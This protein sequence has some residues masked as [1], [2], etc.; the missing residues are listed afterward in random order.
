MR[1]A[2]VYGALAVLAL[3]TFTTTSQA[4]MQA[5]HDTLLFTSVFRGVA[6]PAQY[7]YLDQA[8]VDYGPGAFSAAGSEQSIRFFTI[9]AGDLKFTI[10]RKT[11]MYGPGKNFVVSSGTVVR[12]SNESRTVKARVFV[13]SLVPPIGVDALTVP[14]TRDSSPPPARVYSSRFPVGP[15]PNTIDVYQVGHRYEPG[16][17]TVPHVMNETHD[18]LQLEGTNTYEYLDG[19]VE[20]YGPGQASPMYVGRPGTMGNRGA[21]PSVFVLT[22]VAIP[23]RPLFSPLH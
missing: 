21:T 10:G 17:V 14:G 22:Y 11:D 16:F 23:G 2:F 19:A 12:G 1:R 15:L 5:G 8:I 13:S 9:M 7:F 18:I 3:V 20:T 6:T 4:Q